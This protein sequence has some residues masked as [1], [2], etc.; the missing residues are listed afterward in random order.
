[1]ARGRA[2]GLK[3]EILEQPLVNFVPEV[4]QSLGPSSSERF[5]ENVVRLQMLGSALAAAEA[6]STATEGS[7]STP[8]GSA[9]DR[10]ARAWCRAL[11]DTDLSSQQFLTQEPLHSARSA[12][13]SLTAS[14][15]QQLRFSTSLAA[16]A[17]SSGQ[18]HRALGWLD[19]A[20]RDLKRSGSAALQ[21]SDV[22]RLYW[23]RAQCLWEINEQREALAIA[24]AVTSEAA[25]QGKGPGP[26]RSSSGLLGQSG[27]GPK[28]WVGRAVSLTGMWLAESRLEDN[29]VVRRSYFEPALLCDESDPVPR[30]QFAD[31]LD[32]QL[33]AEVVRQKSVEHSLARDLHNNTQ[34][35]LKSVRSEIQQIETLIRARRRDPK[36]PEL[37]AL[38]EQERKL[39][40][41]CEED[42][43]KF[44]EETKRIRDLARGCIEQCGKCLQLSGDKGLT[45]V[46]CRFLS[47]W[48]DYS[49]DCPEITETV[50]KCIPLLAPFPMTPFI[51][52]LASRLDTPDQAN[53]CAWDFQR[54][55]ESLLVHVI[56][57]SAHGLWPLLQLRNGDQIPHGMRN[58]SRHVADQG[59]ISASERVMAELR[60]RQSMGPVLEAAEVLSKFYI[61]L[62]FRSIDK[63]NREG[64]FDLRAIEGYENVK[65]LLRKNSQVLLPTGP[66]Q[67]EGGP[68]PLTIR[69]F[70]ES[71][72]V[73]AQGISAPKIITLQD[74]SGRHHK[75]VVKGHDDLRQDAVIQQLFRLLNDVFADTAQSRQADLRIRPFQV[76]PLTPCAGIAEWVSG[77]ETL[78]QLLTGNTKPE[79]GAHAVYR[80]QD[81]TH[82]RCRQTMA[83]AREIANQQGP[84]ALK[85]GL[86][87]CYDNFKPVMHLIFLEKFASPERWHK[88]RRDYARSIAV[89][90]IVG[91]IVGIGDRHPNNVLFDQNTGELVHIDFGITFD[92][93]KALRIPELVPFRLSRDIVDGLGCLG[94]CG[95]FRRLSETTMEVLRASSSLI[96]AVVE[97]FV[98]D[99]VYFWSMSWS[100]KVRQDGAAAAEGPEQASGNARSNRIGR[101]GS[102]APLGQSVAAASPSAQS[103]PE[104]GNRVPRKGDDGNEKAKRAVLAVKGKLCGAHGTATALNVSAHV[105]C[106]IHEAIDIN[107]LSK[108]FYGWSPWL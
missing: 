8:G 72:S 39:A 9:M 80:R 45:K 108:M 88:A 73:A 31:F 98:H 102:A 17:R 47:L 33:A 51:Y 54:T 76:V 66:P 23:E 95:Q 13:L 63:K 22:L 68:P 96:T 69:H 103:G 50:K 60:K 57:R 61:N 26:G 25:A 65:L 83:S 18:P 3:A 12:L 38:R 29:D 81:W 74:A 7:K 75:Q 42:D 44:E 64:L 20:Q 37:G 91:Y 92:Q 1:M 79:Q 2:G 94:T 101:S 35:E 84:E 52:Q 40:I 49:S 6:T 77:T 71:F 4:A 70:E 48:F 106:I 93:G 27:S 36:D 105:G 10:L 24:K 100:R 90:S 67:T 30:R 16:S 85:K 5:S 86:E 78:G 19:Q 14:P 87:E 82:Q 62:A 104:N 55:L 34:A 32:E 21:R 56:S 11:Q 89:S 41:Q 53:V 46:A 59:K 97:V 58:A 99:P 15:E 43:Q 107:N 28:N